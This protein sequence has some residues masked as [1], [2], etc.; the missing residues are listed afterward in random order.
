MLKEIGGTYL[1]DNSFIDL[2]MRSKSDTSDEV[3]QNYLYFSL[4]KFIFFCPKFGRRKIGGGD[5]SNGFRERLE[6]DVDGLQATLKQANDRNKPIERPVY[7][8]QGSDSN[9]LPLIGAAAG[10]AIGGPP[11]AVIGGIIG[12]VFGGLFGQNNPKR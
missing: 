12:S 8:D 1:N 9:G 5:I 6:R 4:I 7:Q 11:G 10:A 3:S 2:F